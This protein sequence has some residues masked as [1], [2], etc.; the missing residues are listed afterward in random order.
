[1]LEKAR[2]MMEEV[3]VK[4]Q[5]KIGAMKGEYRADLQ[6]PSTEA[7]SQ[8]QLDVLTQDGTMTSQGSRR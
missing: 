5:Q 8:R 6:G 4:E 2:R 1:M 7:Q 3:P